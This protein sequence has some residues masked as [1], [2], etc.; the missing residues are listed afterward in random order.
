MLKAI[1]FDFDGVLVDSEPLHYRAFLE[2]LAPAGITFDYAQYLAQL[3][4]FDDRDAMRHMLER[5]GKPG[6]DGEV[7]RLCAAKQEVFDRQLA[8]GVAALPGAVELVDAAA[9]ELPLAVA[10]GATRRDVLQILDA[11][12]RR[13]RFEAIVTADDVA[14]S[15]PDPQSYADAVAQLSRRHGELAIEPGAC[16]AIED[17]TTGLASARDA[18]LRTLAV[19]N[20]ERYEA[21]DAAAERVIGSLADINLATLQ[22]WYA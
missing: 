18:G 21:L 7:D 15:K 12:G 4:G 5:H 20:T 13:D 10:S 16:L 3:V 9:G 22:A 19:T 11:L 2:V 6:D 17:T 14:R 1:V 8:T